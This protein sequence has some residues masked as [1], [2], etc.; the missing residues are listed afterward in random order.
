VIS[1]FEDLVKN[2]LLKIYH[3]LYQSYGPMHWWP[4]ETPFEVMVGAI[5]TQNTS[6]KNVEKAIGRLKERKRLSPKGIRQLPKSTLASLIKSSG[7][8]RIKAERLKVFVDFLFEEYGGAIKRMKRERVGGLRQNLLGVKG[9][10]P[11][12]ADSI[13]LYGLQKPIFVVDAYTKRIL[14]RHGIV[15]EKASYE[16]VQNL[17]MDHLPHNE[18][19]FNEYHALLVHLGKTLCKK[20]PSC[21]RCPLKGIE[22]GA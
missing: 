19:L 8:F 18:R 12:T 1:I 3:K 4:G 2:L 7:Y 6:W 5:L 10:G 9:I 22:H 15:S 14:S 16:E 11:E 20:I 17:F 13:L 21:D